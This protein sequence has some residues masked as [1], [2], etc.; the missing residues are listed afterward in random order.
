MNDLK[1]NGTI[2]LMRFLFASAVVLFHAVGDLYS[3]VKKIGHI[4]SIDITFFKNGYI[5]VEF[6]FVISGFFMAKKI[7]KQIDTKEKQKSLGEE[8]VYYIWTKVKTILPYYIP[9]CI[10]MMIIYIVY[11]DNV[12]KIISRIPSLLFLQQT[13]AFEYSFISIA[14]YIS[15]MLIG[16]AIIYP[17]CKKFYSTFTILIAPLLGLLIVGAIIHNT[18][19]LGGVTEW[20]AITYKS[21]FR[22]IAELSLGTTCFEISR[23]ISLVNFKKKSRIILSLAAFICYVVTFLFV[24]CDVPL[25]FSAHAL[26]L[27]CI[28]IIIT[29]SNAGWV[30]R[31]GFMQRK[32]FLYLGSI[33]LP[34]Y[35]FQNVPR[36]LLPMILPDLSPDKQ[37]VLIFVISLLLAV[38]MKIIV[39]KITNLRH[40]VSYQ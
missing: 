2:E 36:Y 8:T 25:T 19:N 22:A 33:S 15:A 26:I 11:G 7:Y 28:A 17:L 3:F 1:R 30:G 16:M 35:L 31:S 37:C 38:L 14:W 40:K 4:G 10:V 18:G 21:N 13:G 6:F 5:G 32:L 24:N 27:I 23:R 39:V 12:I 9:A 20:S 34:L 29:L